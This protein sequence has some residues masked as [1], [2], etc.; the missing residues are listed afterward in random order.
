M[1]TPLRKFL[2]RWVPWSGMVLAGLATAGR[3]L[4]LWSS[5]IERLSHFRLWWIGLLLGLMLWF[6][7][8]KQ[9]WPVVLAALLAVAAVVPLVGYWMPGSDAPANTA[10]S[11]KFIGWN[12]LWENTRHAEAKEWLKEQDADVVLLTECTEEW[13]HDLADLF[14][15]YPHRISSERKGAEGMVLLSR[16]P[17]DP[18]DP[19]GLSEDEPKPWISSIM[20][21]PDGPIRI[22]GLHPRVPR[23]G[24]RFDLRNLQY[25]KAAQI[26]SSSGMPVVVLGDFNC[27]P[28][29]AWFEWLLDRGKLRDSALRYGIHSTWVSNG[30]GL[31]IDHV[32]ISSELVVLDHRVHPDRM[33]SDHHPVIVV[34]AGHPS[35]QA[36]Q[37][38]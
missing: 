6:L 21:A 16:Y 26:A 22:I 36:H 1:K 3:G 25:Q 13:R 32:L 19:E 30:I 14:G 17:L 18:P 7:K 9:R 8:R 4:G 27:T 20:Q 38:R 23:S 33:G 15:R 24:R 34:L 28:F 5:H 29:S 12:L 35:A 11:I 31:P 10:K 37:S 2:T